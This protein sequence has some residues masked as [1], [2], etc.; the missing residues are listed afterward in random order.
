[1]IDLRLGHRFEG[2]GAEDCL[3]EDVLHIAMVSDSRYRVVYA[4]NDAGFL[5]AN[6]FR[7]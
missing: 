7:A 4:F 3:R 6:L 2:I 1:M 5:A